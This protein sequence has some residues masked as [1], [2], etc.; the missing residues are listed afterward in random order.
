MKENSIS[1]LE[2]QAVNRTAGAARLLQAIATNM[3]GIVFTLDREGMFTLFEGQSV[4]TLGLQA[5]Q[6]V[7]LSALEVYRDQPEL[8]ERVRRALG[9]ERFTAE[10]SIHRAPPVVFQTA[11][12]PLYDSD[13]DEFTGILGISND[14]TARKQAEEGLRAAVQRQQEILDTSPTAMMITR[15]DGMVI[16]ANEQMARLLRADLKTVIGG[17]APNFYANPAERAAVLDKIRQAGFL[18]DYE[19]EAVRMDGEHAWASLSVRLFKFAGETAFLSSMIDIT[20]RRQVEQEVAASEQRLR[21]F[22][23][24]QPG[25]V[26]ILDE[27]G[28]FTLSEGRGLATL[29]LQ[30]GQ[31]V[32]LSAFNVYQDSPE[33]CANIRRALAG[34]SLT[35]MVQV[36]GL[37]YDSWYSPLTDSQ[38]RVNGV[39][40]GATDVTERLQAIRQV[41]DSLAETRAR[42]KVSQ[43]LAGAQTEEAVLDGM[44]QAADLYPQ[45]RILIYTA[46]GDPLT[47]TLR[48]DNP[49][50]SGIPPLVPVGTRFAASQFGLVR[51]LAPDKP[52]TSAN[53]MTD[54]HVDAAFRAM[55]ERTGTRAF[56]A[57]PIALGGEWI[58]LITASAKEEGYFD[59]RKIRLYQAL[60][61][62]SAFALRDARLQ[63][64]MR[65]SQQRL[66]L[67]VEQT[68]LGVI[69]WNTNFEVVSWNAAAEKIFGYTRQEA[70]GRHAAGLIVPAAARPLIDPVWRDL[71]AQKGGGRNTNQNMTKDGRMISCEWYNTPLVGADGKVFGV[72]SVIQDITER[73]QAEA[74]RKKLEEENLTLLAR[75]G[76]QVRLSTQ[77][78]QDIAAASSLKDLYQRVVT[79]VQEQFIYYHVQLLRY[80]A[81]QNALVLATGYGE[82]G[83]KML[84]AG[85]RMPMGVGL[86]G[87]AGAQGQTVLRPRLQNDPDWRPNPLLPATRGEIAV[88]IKLGGR[89][90]GVLD[91]QSSEVDS[92]TQDDQLLLEGLCGQIAIAIENTRLREEMQSRLEELNLLYRSASRQGWQT[93]YGEGESGT[94][95]R[96]G[97]WEVGSEEWKRGGGAERRGGEV[98][99]G[100]NLALVYE[101]EAAE[102]TP[103]LWNAAISAAMQ[104]NRLSRSEQG[105]I[106]AP[107]AGRGG[108]VFGAIGVYENP[109]H[110]FSLE[111]LDLIE[112][113][114]QQAALALESARLFAQTQISL[115]QTEEQARRLR[116]LND[117]ASAL[118]AAAD[119][120]EAINIVGSQLLEILQGDQAAVALLLPSPSPTI[121]PG[122]LEVQRMRSGEQKST[123]GTDHRLPVDGSALGECIRRR[124]L[125]TLPQETGIAA[126]PDVQALAEE[127]MQ[128][129]MIAPLLAGGQ[130]IGALLI[131]SRAANAYQQTAKDLFAQVAA[132]TSSVIESRRLLEDVQER[133]QRERLLR[134]VTTKVRASVDAQTILR[135]AVRELGV[136]L[137][138]ETFIRLGDARQSSAAAQSAERDSTQH[139]GDTDHRGDDHRGGERNEH[140]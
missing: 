2:G 135:T 64:A 131:A 77:V 42:L 109:Q 105:Q 1:S 92:L 30:P 33:I 9:G 73:L 21:T 17:K 115:A 8:L 112:Q 138:R 28:R 60:A 99:R 32:G 70:L 140:A 95:N 55:G 136:A 14:I 139:R 48:R 84:A 25:V 120:K 11:Y 72:A 27:E 127:G 104:E 4:A 68:P 16:Y 90:L 75:R 71:L 124:Q 98:G 3:P 133:A 88:P 29:G 51:L 43:A 18:Q 61:E 39:I 5:G 96:S 49:F 97:K 121:P 79:Q 85:H 19:M 53:L 106:A 78:A 93:I 66:A 123:G 67:L 108:D 65:A 6:L 47:F 40:G 81:G 107:L 36:G 23:A 87:L 117:L 69:E 119:S 20:A 100:Q 52:Y 91:V 54:S 94:E 45:A 132:L 134:E 74:E 113:V 103:G 126:L 82:T 114:S 37:I 83:A 22:V 44:L 35:G 41:E 13:T 129:L 26:F 102:A 125:L 63:E 57:I 50:Q 89:L 34:E 15:L 10:I 38:G 76:L 12:T 7:G 130:T 128:S 86:I 80:D 118:S 110:P 111:D 122:T 62:Q 59:E 101:N 116:Q 137:G 58:G 31:V 24:N 56:A 46:E